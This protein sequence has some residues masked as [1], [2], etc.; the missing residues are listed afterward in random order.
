MVG[1]LVDQEMR[2]LLNRI[3]EAVRDL[4]WNMVVLVLR[5]HK[6]QTTYPVAVAAA[7]P[8]MRATLL[9]IPPTPFR[10]NA[11]QQDRFR[12]SRSYFV[13]HRLHEGIHIFTDEAGQGVYQID[14]GPRRADEWQN[15]DF[16]I[17]P[18][19]YENEEFGWLSVDD[20]ADRQRPTITNVRALEIFADQAALTIQQ[21]RLLVDLRQQMARQE[22]LNQLAHTITHHLELIE[23]FPS[24]TAQLEQIFAFERLSIILRDDTLAKARLFVE[25]VRAESAPATAPKPTTLERIA[26]AQVIHQGAAH[27]LVSDVAAA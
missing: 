17:I 21:A 22:V 13:D 10:Q 19:I 2:M 7:E 16:L 3:V 9:A 23:L 1:L 5:D 27:H 8:T 24:I 18:L 15:D 4:G 12:L 6:T 14:L 20:P 11:W 25:D 26:F